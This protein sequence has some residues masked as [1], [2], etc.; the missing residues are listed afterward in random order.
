MDKSQEMRT[1]L[2]GL[3]AH[4]ETAQ[5]LRQ[6]LQ[7]AQANIQSNERDAHKVEE[8]A[9]RFLERVNS[10]R[11]Q[12]DQVR[13]IEDELQQVYDNIILPP[14]FKCNTHAHV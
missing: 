12:L 4:L 7:T 11:R 1:E 10:C 8:E 6:E 3:N 9:E 2:A 13:G 14:K 5:L